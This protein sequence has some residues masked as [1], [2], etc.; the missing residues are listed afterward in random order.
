MEL[1][2]N[3]FPMYAPVWKAKI[4]KI[5]ANFAKQSPENRQVPRLLLTENRKKEASP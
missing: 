2:R 1:S 5:A 3:Y 4:R